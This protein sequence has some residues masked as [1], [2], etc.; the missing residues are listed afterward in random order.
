MKK[1]ETL[2]ELKAERCRLNVVAK[3]ME[4]ELQDDFQHLSSRI[5]PFLSIFGDSKPSGKVSSLL[6]KEAIAILPLLLSR[7]KVKA[8]TSATSWMTL[9]ATALG[10]LA[11]RKVDG[12][13]EKI[14]GFL[15]SFGKKKKKYRRHQLCR[16]AKQ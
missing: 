7:R 10:L 5:Q 14:A 9:G 6:L 1:I 15:G 16:C 12:L 4:N 13:L 8:R 3:Q 2:E 11:G